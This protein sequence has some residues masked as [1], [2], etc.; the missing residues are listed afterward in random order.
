MFLTVHAAAAAIIGKKVSSPILAF[1]LGILSH[2]ILDTIPHGDQE[3]GKKFFGFVFKTIPKE[4][5]MVRI[6]AMYGLL[7]AFILIIY[8]IF[9]FRT[10]DFAKSDSVTWAII[11]GILPDVLV[12]L[13]ILGSFKFLKW[14]YNFHDK[15]H[16]I[17]LRRMKSDIHLNYGLTVQALLMAVAI[18]LIY[19]F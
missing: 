13:Y 17:F 11:G 16:H 2:F 15:N 12:G 5:K 8:I 14:F 10:F 4:K 3:L 1:F 18:F 19:R 6:L 7:D 9:L